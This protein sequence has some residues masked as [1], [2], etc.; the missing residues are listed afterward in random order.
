[1]IAIGVKRRGGRDGVA[2][3][4]RARSA[5]AGQRVTLRLEVLPDSPLEP[6]LLA[7]WGSPRLALPP[8]ED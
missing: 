8:A 7:S 5:Y 2:D 1:M 3:D 4:D 6:G